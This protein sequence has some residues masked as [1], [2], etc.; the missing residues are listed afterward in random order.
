MKKLLYLGIVLMLGSCGANES[1]SDASNIDKLSGL[2]ESE[3]AQTLFYNSTN[4]ESEASSNVK[5]EGRAVSTIKIGDLEVMTEYL[6]YMKWDEAK[7][8]CEDAGDGW[9]LPTMNELQVLYENKEKLKRAFFSDK[10]SQTQPLF[11][12]WSSEDAGERLIPDLRG[13]N[14]ARILGDRV[15][16]GSEK[17]KPISFAW[18]MDLEN[19]KEENYPLDEAAFSLAVRGEISLEMQKNLEDNRKD[20]FSVKI[21]KLEVKRT[22][23]SDISSSWAWA[24]RDLEKLEGGWRLP[25]TDELKLMY[26]NK[27]LIGGF[28]EG[29]NKH[30]YWSSTEDGWQYAMQIRFYDGKQKY[31]GK[32]NDGLVRAVRDF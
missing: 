22:D 24:K 13:M 32:T 14:T 2:N 23:L 28:I 18:M 7:K 9:R 21:G 6:G 29:K 19:G 3:T 17:N 25:T 20:K 5:E 27:E 1:E 8:A 31:E 11:S 10:T 12:S 4:G 15:R 30:A 26:E 16:G